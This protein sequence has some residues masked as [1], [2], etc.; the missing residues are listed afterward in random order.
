[1]ASLYLSCMDGLHERRRAR[2]GWQS[3]R[4]VIPEEE[5]QII[6]LGLEMNARLPGHGVLEGAPDPLDRVPRGALWGPAEPPDVL[7]QGELGGRVRPTVVPQEAVEAVRN[8]LGDG[9]DAAWAHLGVQ[10]RP[11]QEAPS[12]RRPLHG[13]IAIAPRADRRDG[14]PRRPPTRGEAPA[15]D[16]AAAD[17]A[18]VLAAPAHRTGGGRRHHVLEACPTG[19]LERGNGLRGVWV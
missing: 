8:G 6:L 19:R 5:A 10:V 15:A 16:G 2:Q 9:L 13:A 12:A 7:G 3:G 18:C 1:M 14:S 11:R 17:A 4:F